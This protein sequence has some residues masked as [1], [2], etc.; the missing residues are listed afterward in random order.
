MI[1]VSQEYV[2]LLISTLV[3]GPRR[4]RGD[5]VMDV[6]F[7]CQADHVSFP[8]QPVLLPLI[9]F[10]AR[11]LQSVNRRVPNSRTRKS[12]RLA[13]PAGTDIRTVGRPQQDRLV[14]ELALDAAILSDIP[15]IA[16]VD[17]VLQRTLT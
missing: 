7:D 17:Q 13:P 15:D 14:D 10:N 6:S 9:W 2:R 3:V 8:V 1:S 12:R 4:V 16:G 5:A 11:E